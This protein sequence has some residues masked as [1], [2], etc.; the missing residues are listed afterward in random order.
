[1]DSSGKEVWR[2]SKG[3]VFT[4]ARWE[5]TIPAGHNRVYQSTIPGNLPGGQYT[6]RAYFP[7]AGPNPVASAKI[8][9]PKGNEASSLTFQFSF[10]AAGNGFGN[11]YHRLAFQVSNHTSRA[12]EI[13][14]PS[15][16]AYRIV[17]KDSSSSVVWDHSGQRWDKTTRETVSAGSTRYHFIRLPDLPKGRYS[18]EVYFPPA[19]TQPVSRLGFTIP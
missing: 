11:N 12:L 6:I 3:K 8:E 14:Y 7:P 1:V 13:E 10:R 5:D 2:D 16:V 17:V 15:Q 9:V 18:A 19:G 4:Q